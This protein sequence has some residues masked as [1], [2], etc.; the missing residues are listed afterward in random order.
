VDWLAQHVKVDFLEG[1]QLPRLSLTLED[2]EEAKVLVDG[3]TDAYFKE[4]VNKEK[5]ERNQLLEKLTTQSKT[6]ADRL[7]NINEAIKEL[8]KNSGIGDPRTASIRHDSLL[9]EYKETIRDLRNTNRELLLLQVE[10]TEQGKQ[11]DLPIL[12]TAAVGLAGSP[13][14][15][16]S[17]VPALALTLGT[18]KKDDAEA[19]RLELL[20]EEYLNK[21]PNISKLQADIASSEAALEETRNRVVHADDPLVRRLEER[22]AKQ[23]KELESL[24]KQRRPAAEKALRA[25]MAVQ[26]LPEEA[27]PRQRQIKWL[28]KQKQNLEQN[29][30]IL[31]KSAGDM[32][33]GRLDLDD[34]REDQLLEAN[35]SKYLAELREK[36]KVDFDTP[37]RVRLLEP[38]AIEHI[39]EVPRKLRFAGLA[40]LA[41]LALT[42]LGVSFLEFR[43]HRV[44][45]PEAVVQTLG[46][47]LVGTVPAC[48]PRRRLLAGGGENAVYWQHVLTDCI[49]SARTMLVHRAQSNGLRTVLITSAVSGEGKTSLASHLAISLIRAGYKTLLIDCDL[50]H[51]ALHQLFEQALEPGFCELLRGECTLGQVLRPTSVAGLSFISAGR[52]DPEALRLLAQARGRDVLNKLRNDFEFVIVDSSPLLPVADALL[53]AQL[54]DGALLSLLCDVSRLPRVHE[55]CARL[56]SLGVTMLGAVVNGTVDHSADYSQN[57][58]YQGV[59]TQKGICRDSES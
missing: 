7:K 29:L 2:P 9:L 44:D 36:L 10:E 18:T 27:I 20:V 42:L 41:A 21:D 37:P 49:D 22:L 34:M 28:L 39:E 12:G 47:N 31:N 56:A 58:Y 4:V 53:V 52:L 25:R 16:G 3:I 13:L 57:Y 48:P 11:Q 35:L 46:M 8:G 55:A 32:D 50:R 5:D 23:K 33:R 17:F 1:P 26:H 30:A 15:Q 6:H 40:A 14:G 43:L 51:P 24:H 59:R 45:S 19:A 54:V 38:A